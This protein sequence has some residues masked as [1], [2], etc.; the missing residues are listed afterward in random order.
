MNIP[1]ATPLAF[2]GF[3]CLGVGAF[4]VLAGSGIVKVERVSVAQ[5]TR[6]WVIG[7]VLAVLGVALLFPELL[8]SEA[9]D[10]KPAGSVTAT[11]SST[12]DGSSDSTDK[13]ADEQAAEATELGS[14]W[15][16]VDFDIPSAKFWTKTA[17]GSYHALGDVDTFAWSG[18]TIDGDFEL[19]LDV[20]SDHYEDSATVV[21]YGNGAGFSD[22][23]LIVALESRESRIQSH[24]V[25]DGAE[26]LDVMTSEIDLTGGAHAVTIEVRDRVAT[27]TFDGSVI[28]SASL[29]DDINSSGQLALYKWGGVTGSTMSNVRIRIPGESD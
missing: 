29:G 6:T 7:A 14:E 9:A 5:G 25:Y 26:F 13:E 11:E 24:T 2:I 18:E 19:A 1:A 3:I 4:M 17:E 27:V 20:Q 28:L 22:G 8:P 16:R 15:A 23:C 21:I 10:E 12:S